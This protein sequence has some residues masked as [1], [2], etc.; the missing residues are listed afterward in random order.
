MS[1]GQRRIG[2]I[3]IGVL[4][5]GLALS[6]ASRGYPVVA[7]HSRSISSARWLGDR[8][9]TCQVYPSAQELVDACDLVFIT[10]PDS[11]IEEVASSLSWRDGQG[12]VHCCGASSTEILASAARQGGVTGAFHPFQTFAGLEDPESAGARLAGVTFAV[13]GQGWL[14]PYL[15]VM[16]RNLGGTPAF[17]E[18]ADRPLYHGAAVLG[19]GFLTALLQGAVSLWT[20]MG[21]TPEEAMRAL[22]PLARTTLENAERMGTVASVTGP[23]VR[24]DT[25][26]LEAHLTA[27]LGRAPELV[28]LYRALAVA[29]LPLA[30]ER[31]VP[32]DRLEAMRDLIDTVDRRL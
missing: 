1:E 10:T 12:V 25:P 23:V 6:L 14:E 26:T 9:S 30:E 20:G 32:P 21:F 4:G 16:A 11:A 7:A 17:I 15:Q 19:C 5:K 13:S 29:S 22:F 27:L 28:P 31:G 24:G 2:F 18:D 3:G 8:L